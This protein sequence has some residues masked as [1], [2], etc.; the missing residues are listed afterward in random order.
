MSIDHALLYCPFCR[1]NKLAVIEDGRPRCKTCGSTKVEPPHK[2]MY[3]A[4]KR[5]KAKKVKA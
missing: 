5:R 3:Y 4:M 2:P 1:A